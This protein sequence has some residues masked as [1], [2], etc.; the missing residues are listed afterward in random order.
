MGASVAPSFANIFVHN[1][2]EKRFV[3][4]ILLLWNG[5]QE[6]L[7]EMVNEAN[8]CH[9]TVK[10]TVEV[11]DIEIIFLDVNLVINEGKILTKLYRKET[12]RNSILH[13][14]TFHNPST[15]R[16]IPKGQFIRAKRI[17]TLNTDYECSSQ[18]M[19]SWFVERGYSPSNLRYTMEEVSSLS[20]ED[21]L[22]GKGKVK[23]N[24][25]RI[26]FILQYVKHS[27]EIEKVVKKYWPIIQGDR[28]FGKLFVQPILFS[29][30]K[31]RS[32][33]D[34]LCPAVPQ[35]VSKERFLGT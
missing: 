24:N 16:A 10:F 9:K 15:I 21:L 17:T 34:V 2:E 11:S 33:R 13:A 6:L 28:Q 29:Y 4:D 32:I 19:L 5:T 3:D 30:K 7:L 12:E 23:K 1:L 22:Q 31:G 35:K 26:P 20:R 27:K 18:V 14:N 25:T 8:S